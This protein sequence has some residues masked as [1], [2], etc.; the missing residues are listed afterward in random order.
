LAALVDR[1][2]LTQLGSEPGTTEVEEPRFAMLE[3]VREYGLEQLSGSADEE[4]TYRAHAA[5]CLMTVER[6]APGLWGPDPARWLDALEREHANV[7]QALA[8]TADHPVERS[9]FVRLA[10]A[11]RWFW[12]LRGHLRE[13]RVWLDRAVALSEPSDA[14][15]VPVS[16]ELRAAALDG[17]GDLAWSLGDFDRAATLHAESLAISRALGDQAAIA[18]ALF[19]LGDVA[20]RRA[21]P[22]AAA[23]FAEALR[24]FDDLGERA[25]SAFAL[26][27][28]AVVAMLQDGDLALATERFDQALSRAREA[29][30]RW[31]EAVVLYFSGEAHRA[32]GD[33]PAAATAYAESLAICQEIGEQRGIA[34]SLVGLG[35]IAGMR[36][37]A[38]GQDLAVR[39]YGAAEILRERLG[40]PHLTIAGLSYEEAVALAREALGES[41][42]TGAWAAGRAM[43]RPEA[44]AAALA[45]ASSS[46][47]PTADQIRETPAVRSTGGL[48][49]TPGLPADTPLSPLSPRELEVLSLVCAGRS[50]RE[51]AEDL[52][53]SHRTVTTHIANIF[54][55]I[56][57]DSR[58]AAVAYAHRHGLL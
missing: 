40:I 52:F 54:T 7:H 53:V 6:A 36:G 29:R 8:W 56:G 39:L 4:A 46:A 3:T 58:A 41:Q 50:T 33:L 26:N 13:G 32:R 27:N 2:L 1:S 34:F 21:D 45:V 17:A 23:H 22:A 37:G 16:P 12:R 38:N 35:V 44:V 10:T 42:F 5:C 57:V 55:K 19:G 9:T 14:G 28:S 31:G 18:R 24:I 48:P 11:L 20:R 15:D 43:P 51:I 25:W 49:T 47:P 30:F